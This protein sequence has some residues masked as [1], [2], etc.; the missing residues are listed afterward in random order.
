MMPVTKY[1]WFFLPVSKTIRTA[2]VEAVEKKCFFFHVETFNFS[3][4]W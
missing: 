3:D 2:V 4:G 1:H